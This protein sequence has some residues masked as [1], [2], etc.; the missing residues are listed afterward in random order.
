MFIF[1][2]YI[3]TPRCRRGRA[4]NAHEGNRGSIPGRDIP[5]SLKQER[6]T[7][8]PDSRVTVGMTR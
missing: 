4:F 8:L 1:P 7:P 2:I 3:E 5:K 6:T